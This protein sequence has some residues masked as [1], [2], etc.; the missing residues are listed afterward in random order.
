MLKAVK[1]K[2]YS[3]DLLGKDNANMEEITKQATA[4]MCK[5]YGVASATTMTRARINV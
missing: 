4:F 5:C 1:T 3:L 2:E